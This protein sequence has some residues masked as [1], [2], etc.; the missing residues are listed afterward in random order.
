[1]TTKN[2]T[3]VAGRLPR[4]AARGVGDGGFDGVTLSSV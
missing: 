2:E 1:M 3:P 4:F